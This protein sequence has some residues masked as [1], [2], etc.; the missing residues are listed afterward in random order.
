[1]QL[2]SNYWSD[3]SR[4]RK[5]LLQIVRKKITFID[6]DF[7]LLMMQIMLYETYCKVVSVAMIKLMEINTTYLTTST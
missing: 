3:F 6:S 4:E 1:M 7:N 2:Q 5:S